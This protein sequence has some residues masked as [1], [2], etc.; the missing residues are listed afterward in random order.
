[1]C[2]T[3]ARPN[4]LLYHTWP[5]VVNRQNAQK[6]VSSCGGH[7]L[8]LSLVDIMEHISIYNHRKFS[9]VLLNKLLYYNDFYLKI[10][11]L[12]RPTKNNKVL[13]L[14]LYHKRLQ[15]FSIYQKLLGLF[16]LESFLAYAHR[17][18]YIHTYTILNFLLYY[19]PLSH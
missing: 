7:L 11:M 5:P 18:Y 1:M 14:F 3:S 8:C 13:F 15:P 19:H 17:C 16:F 6:K 9:N 12:L 2:P 4:L 10:L